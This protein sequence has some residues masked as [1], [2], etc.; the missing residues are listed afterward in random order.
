MF[1]GKRN[2]YCENDCTPKCNLQTQYDTYEITNGI[3]HRTK[4]KN[5]TIH[6]ETQKTLNS[7]SS[8]EKRM[9]LEEASFPT[10]GYPTK[11]QSSR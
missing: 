3:F 6:M 7:Q 5:F 8:P 4:A 10:S 11:L 2:Q 9:E 1:L